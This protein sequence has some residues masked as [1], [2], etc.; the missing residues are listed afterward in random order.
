MKG[1]R[2]CVWVCMSVR[3]LACVYVF[4]TS[5]YLLLCTATVKCTEHTF[6]PTIHTT[7]MYT[8]YICTHHMY[9]CAFKFICTYISCSVEHPQAGPSSPF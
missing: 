6:M 1:E 3:V 4:V 9:T 5:P 8:V 2:M 7:Y